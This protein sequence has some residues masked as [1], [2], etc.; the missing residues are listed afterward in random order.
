MAALRKLIIEV[1]KR[2]LNDKERKINFWYC[3]ASRLGG[4]WCRKGSS[5]GYS[6]SKFHPL[7]SFF[8]VQAKWFPSSHS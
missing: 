4:H 6:R 5:T 1:E 8:T 2:F 3:C 7:L